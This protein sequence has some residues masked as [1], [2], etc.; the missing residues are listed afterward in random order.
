MNKNNLRYCMLS[1]PTGFPHPQEKMRELGIT[2]EKAEPHSVVDS[3]LFFGC[4]NVPDELPD[5]LSEVPNARTAKSIYEEGMER[6][7]NTPAPEGQKFPPGCRVKIIGD[8]HPLISM[9]S[10]LNGNIL[11]ESVT[12]SRYVGKLATVEYTYSHAFGGNAVSTYS[13]DI[14]GIGSHAWH[15]EE[16]LE[17]LEQS[18]EE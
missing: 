10:D 3:W 12:Q 16:N 18:N 11:E 14:D 9:T 17:L 8:S 15:Q 4:E 6:V 13:L 7:K 2:Y 5:Y 1:T